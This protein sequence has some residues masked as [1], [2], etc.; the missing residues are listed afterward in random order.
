MEF[1]INFGEDL[2]ETDL[3]DMLDQKINLSYVDYKV[4]K[5]DYLNENPTILTSEKAA[6]AKVSQ[7]WTY[8]KFK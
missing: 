6:L 1:G 5:D 8:I 2:L 7:I 4:T 3:E